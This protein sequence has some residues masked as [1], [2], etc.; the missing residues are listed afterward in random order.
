MAWGFDGDHRVVEPHQHAGDAPLL[1]LPDLEQVL[2]SPAPAP[3]KCHEPV[4]Y[5]GSSVIDRE[6]GAPVLRNTSNC[7]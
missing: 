3:V 2:D 7:N 6:R 4:K 1:G 5:H